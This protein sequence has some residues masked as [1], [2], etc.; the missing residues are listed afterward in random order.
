MRQR[1]DRV[2][3]RNVSKFL[4]RQKRRPRHPSVS[5]AA[6]RPRFSSAPIP[7]D[8]TATQDQRLAWLEHDASPAPQAT[9]SGNE[10]GSSTVFHT[11]QSQS[12][13]NGRKEV[14]YSTIGYWLWHLRPVF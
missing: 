10:K 5:T 11:S 4:R 9:T 2:S 8:R 13:A 3:P 7:Q 12:P 1:T 6:H 14:A